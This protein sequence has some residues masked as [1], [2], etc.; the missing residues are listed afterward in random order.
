MILG[1]NRELHG[2]GNPPPGEGDEHER[3]YQRLADFIESGDQSGPPGEDD[4]GS[5]DEAIQ[6]GIREYL[7]AVAVVDRIAR[8]FRAVAAVSTPRLPLVLNDYELLEEIGWGGTATVYRA[9]QRALNRIVAI[10]VLRGGRPGTLCD[11]ARMR[12]EAEAVAGL[13]HPGIV[14]VY[15]VGEWE[16]RPYFSMKLYEGGSLANHLTEFRER[17]RDAA[18]VV[19]SIAQAIHF[20]HQRGI[21]HRD[22]KP[23][24]VLLDADGRPHVADFGLAKR[25]DTDQDITQTGE[26]IGT[27][28]YMAPE[29]IGGSPWFGPATIA[30]DVYGVGAILYALLTGRAPFEAE[31]SIQA[32]QAAG[33]ED[34][35]RP[36]A[37]NPKIDPDL[38]TICLKCLEKEPGRRYSTARDVADELQ[39]WL[40]GEPIVARQIP[41]TERAR[42]WCRRHPVRLT[43]GI[44]SLALLLTVLGGLTTGYVLLR[45]SNSIAETHRASAED[46]A[47]ALADRLYAAR[48]TSGRELL[49]RGDLQR[50]RL[51]LNEFSDQPERQGFEW[52]WLKQRVCSMP[53]EVARFMEHEHIVYGSDFSPD[54]QLVASCGAD[55]LIK[56]WNSETGRWLRTLDPDSGVSANGERF[57]EDCVDFSPDGLWLASSGEN[58]AVHLWDL[59]TGTPHE[60]LPR[61]QGETYSVEFSSDG[62]WLVAACADR[63]VRVWEVA[64]RKLAT[65]FAGHTTTV[66]WA[67]FSPDGSEVASADQEGTICVWHRDRGEL[68]VQINAGLRTN[69]V[70]WSPDGRHLA[71]EGPGGSVFLWD[72]GA[73]SQ[74][75]ALPAAGGIR[76]LTFSPDSG[77]LAAAGNDGCV[78]I[79]SV[80]DRL[81]ERYFKAHRDVIWSARFDRAGNRLLTCSTDRTAAVWD[82]AETPALDPPLTGFPQPIRHLAF[83]GDGRRLAVFTVHSEFWIGDTSPTAE[84]RRIPIDIRAHSGPVSSPD[85]RELAFIGAGGEIH[86]WDAG[87]EQLSA[88]FQPPPPDPG[89]ED[90]RLGA[91]LLRYLPDH[92]LAALTSQGALWMRTGTNWEELRPARSGPGHARLLAPMADGSLFAMC[93]LQPEQIQFWDP[94]Q[95]TVDRIIDVGEAV[96]TGAVSPDEQWLAG[97]FPDGSI[98]LCPLDS[99]RPP[100]RLMG[101]REGISCL[102]FSPDSRT[103]ASSSGDG[104]VR[105][106]H[107]R[108]GEELFVLEARRGAAFTFAFSPDGEL[109]AVGGDVGSD[110]AM[111]SIYK[112]D[113]P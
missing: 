35:A 91:V 72:A 36:A 100:Q 48:M 46:K 1:P 53:R 2:R 12:F 45:E 62:S 109:L 20:A 64:S 80:S 77:R 93:D 21:L 81:L 47:R 61:P 92:R 66:K 73:G 69:V 58:G 33:A 5:A 40:A 60:L 23:S 83:F 59:A 67:V 70:A 27:P 15:E 30:T 112:A 42:R 32:L 86:C 113:S 29:R 90:W 22:L 104:E 98:A 78:R 84:W 63:I 57:D 31:T 105:L 82:F 18:S 94:K 99:A 14:P 28:A 7:A 19:I 68:R 65:G 3:L 56:L 25:L 17:L 50:L 38:N 111:L 8:P 37:L 41:L 97:G 108:T 16:G 6:S 26:L 44:A 95:G 9:R 34:P 75:A 13:E 11:G 79:W 107:V 101:H 87:T 49:E 52:R 4:L 102:Q 71:T 39:R 55:G 110:G 74:L 54:G 96:L 76:T 88:T 24:N 43:A 106:W 85:G 103:L 89:H 10:K 51:L